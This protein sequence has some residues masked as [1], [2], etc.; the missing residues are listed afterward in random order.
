MFTLRIARLGKAW[1]FLLVSCPVRFQGLR[2][3]TVVG[4]AEPH[5]GSICDVDKS[6]KH[7]KQE[8]REIVHSPQLEEF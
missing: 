5:F 4:E 7:P 6:G 1:A 3:R 2:P 8:A